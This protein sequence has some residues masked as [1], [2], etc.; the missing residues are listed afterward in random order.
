MNMQ[1]LVLSSWQLLLVCWWWLWWECSTCIVT[2][3]LTSLSSFSMPWPHVC[4]LPRVSAHFCTVSCL[5]WQGA[6]W[7]VQCLMVMVPK[8]RITSDTSVCPS[9][10]QLNSELLKVLHYLPATNITKCYRN[11]SK[12]PHCSPQSPSQVHQLYFPD[13]TYVHQ[14]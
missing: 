8:L 6:M 7:F 3:P 4:C 11:G 10:Q 2:A 9:N 14:F 5:L 13:S 12:R 1:E